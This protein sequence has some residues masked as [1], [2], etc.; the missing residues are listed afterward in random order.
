MDLVI[1]KLKGYLKEILIYFSFYLFFG[2][3]FIESISQV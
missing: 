1:L 2:T 3:M